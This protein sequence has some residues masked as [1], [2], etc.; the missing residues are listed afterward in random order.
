M[1][2]EPTN[3]LLNED[4]L[5]EPKKTFREPSPAPGR[6][7]IGEMLMEEGLLTN[8]QLQQALAGQKELGIKLG[9]YLIQKNMVDE[10]HVVRLLAR[11]LRVGRYDKERF[12]PSTELAEVVPESLAHRHLLV[13]L[14]RQGSLLWLA[15]MDPTDLDAIDLV[16]KTSGYDVEPV[17]CTEQ[18]YVSHF[19]GVYG[20]MLEGI[21][22]VEVEQ[23]QSITVEDSTVT[24]SSLQY[25][26]EDAPVV[27]LVNSVL[28]QALDRGASDIHIQPKHKD[29]LL[30]FRVDGKL[31]EAPAPPKAFYLP[32]ISRIKL[33]SNM[34]ISISRVPQDGRFT[35]RTRDKEISVRT[36]TTPTIYGE[37]VVMRMLN[38]SNEV[39]DFTELGM[40]EREAKILR[41]ATRRPY[42][43]ILATGPTGSGKT[44]LLYSVLDKLN[45]IDVNIVTLEDPVEY[46]VENICQIQLNRKAGMTFA[47]GLRSVLRQDPDIIMVG[48]I[49]DLETADIAIKS[50]LTGHKV[51]STLHTNNAADTITR[52]VE[53]GIE[54]F[55]VA[56]TLLV[57]V[58]QRLVRRLCDDCAVEEP[59]TSKQLKILGVKPSEGLTIRKAVGCQKCG[60]SG[61]KGRIGVFEILEIDE[62]IQDMVI[63]RASAHQIR[64]A[65]VRAGTLVTLKQN[66]AIKVLEGQTSLE[67]YMTIAFEL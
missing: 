31:E 10:S 33:L 20:R 43:L 52:M 19:Y 5:A 65:A 62:N 25:M 34:D 64:A 7:R 61:Y 56:S 1:Q 60:R 51:L 13:P 12:P 50:A 32:F 44:T 45:K 26:A 58:A 17:I 57:S 4:A 27:K 55:L 3:P 30:R 67:E 42:G 39:M 23:E 28:V 15:M 63:K 24:I 49:R 47:S 35:Y 59:A 41:T 8:E 40:S 38:Q 6:K 18:E 11:Q 14:Q 36:S 53:M 37:K 46:R 54:P 29:V 21:A 16:M 22:D 48:E 9:Q 66:A 2:H